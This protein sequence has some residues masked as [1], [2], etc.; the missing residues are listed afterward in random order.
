[1]SIQPITHRILVKPEDVSETKYK[2]EIKGF[3]IAGDQ[4]EREQKGVDKGT[5]LRM[6]PTAFLDY[7]T[8]NPLSV[9]DTIVFAK[10]AGK[11]VEDPEFPDE[12]FVLLNDE[13]V[14]AIVRNTERNEAVE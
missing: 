11:E 6:G 4:K 8:V 12:K 14:I 7:D 10:Y 3:V 5:V 13:D 9:G 2:T 1:M